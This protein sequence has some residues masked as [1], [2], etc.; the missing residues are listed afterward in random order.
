MCH[1]ETVNPDLDGHDET[2]HS[3]RTERGHPRPH[4]KGFP[5]RCGPPQRVAATDGSE[6][7]ISEI[8]FDVENSEIRYCR[9]VKL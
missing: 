8:S 2:L 7:K 5:G 4:A 6:E 3:R 1:T 9:L